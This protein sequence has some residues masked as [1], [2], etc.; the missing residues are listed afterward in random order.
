MERHFIV[1]FSSLMSSSF[2]IPELLV[3]LTLAEGG[4]GAAP[5]RGKFT[6][7]KKTVTAVTAGLC[8]HLPAAVRHQG[9]VL[10]LH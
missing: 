5:V 10:L 9:G 3:R 6:E 2:I 1:C 7:C 4:R 8:P